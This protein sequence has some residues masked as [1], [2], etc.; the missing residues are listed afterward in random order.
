MTP[1]LPPPHTYHVPLSQT[2]SLAAGLPPAAQTGCDTARTVQLTVWE[3]A[4]GS[5]PDSRL[6]IR[7]TRT[8][9]TCN[10]AC[11]PTHNTCLFSPGCADTACM[12]W[13]T[14]TFATPLAVRKKAVY[15]FPVDP[16]RGAGPA[17]RAHGG[18]FGPGCACEWGGGGGS[19]SESPMA[20][21]FS[22]D[23]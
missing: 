19:R 7:E 14:W 2:H 17:R 15:T 20:M 22:Q 8:F 3:G 10:E 23:A 11:A 16:V 1:P 21:L 12:A 6:L 18:A 5:D 9:T 4:G 13:E